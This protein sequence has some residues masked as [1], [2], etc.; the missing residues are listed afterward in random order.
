MIVDRCSVVMLASA[1]SAAL[2]AAPALAAPGDGSTQDAIEAADAI[3]ATPA[4]PAKPAADEPAALVVPISPG[5]WTA[6]RVAARA[7]EA[8]T[9]VAVS[10]VDRIRAETNAEWRVAEFAPRLD[11]RATYTRLSE[12]D[13]PPFQFGELTIDSP[14]PQI[15]DQY[16]LQASLTV[17]VTDAFLAILPAWRAAKGTAEVARWQTETERASAALRARE[18]FYGFA[19]VEAARLVADDS[20]RLLDAYIDDLAALFGAGQVTEADVLQ[21]RARRAEAFGQTLRLASAHRVAAENL[22]ILLDL[23]PDAPIAIGEDITRSPA[24][25]PDGDALASGWR[26]RPEVAAL[27]ALGTVYQHSADAA[28]ASRWPSLSLRGNYT[29]ANPNQRV[30]PQAERFDGSWDVSVILAWSPN[31]LVSG[32]A[33]REDALLEVDRTTAELATL[34]EGLALQLA[35]SVGDYQAATAAL[36]AADEQVAA[37]HAAWV[38][39]RDLLRA[40]EATPNDVLDAESALRRAQAALFDVRIDCHLARARIDHAIGRA[41]PKSGG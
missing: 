35:Q 14:F 8:S 4:Q 30:L 38:L 3:P 11:L 41:V 40:G 12:I 29:Y 2:L 27:T 6:E 24:G 21:A 32:I 31:S 28:G 5:G 23:P 1:F 13:Q 25:L 36:A 17:P 18:A 22:R 15:L 19:R 37:A 9:R 39:Q 7:V 33:R 26:D 16:A 34:R 20:V 10:E